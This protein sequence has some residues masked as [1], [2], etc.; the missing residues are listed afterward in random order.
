MLL[1]QNKSNNN[2]NKLKLKNKHHTYIQL[3]VTK[4]IRAKWIAEVRI[5]NGNLLGFGK[6]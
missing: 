4:T 6:W 2:N 5:A 1:K 3:K